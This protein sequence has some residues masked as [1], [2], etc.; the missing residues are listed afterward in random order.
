MSVQGKDDS[1]KEDEQEFSKRPQILFRKL[2]EHSTDI[3]TLIAADGRVSYVSPSI[4]EMLGY[5]PQE[6]VGLHALS[7]IHPDDLSKM[8]RLFTEIMQSSRYRLSAEYR[9]RCKDGAWRWFEGTATNLLH[10][11]DVQAI[12]GNF[13][14]ITERKALEEELKKSKAQL[15]AI[16][17]NV[18]DG[19]TAQDAAGKLIYANQAAALS[20]G[21]ASIEAV[22][23]APP[24][25][26]IERFE[27]TDEYGQPFSPS[28]FPGRRALMG[29][30]HPQVTIKHVHKQTK[31]VRWSIITST[32]ILS[33]EKRP[34][35]VINVIQDITRLKELEQRKD[36]FISMASH[37]LR[38][39]VTS[40]K[41]YTQLL[42]KK[43]EREHYNE[44]VVYLGRMD[45][46]INKL[47][48]LIK[49]LLDVSKAQ[50]GKLEYAQECVDIDA[51]IQETIETVQQ[52][53]TTHRFFVHG[54]S[55]V[56][57]NGDGERLGQVLINLLNNAIKYS[58][59]AN[60]VDIEVDTSPDVVRITVRDYGIGIPQ[61]HQDKLFERFYRVS[62]AK[63]NTF[64]GLG[65]GLYIAYEIVLR[66]GGKLWLES[67]EGQGSAF[68]ISLPLLKNAEN[69]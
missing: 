45:A 49:D 68:S 59:G 39:P 36:T 12:V 33:D 57:V 56:F 11:Q 31:E 1:R 65:I 22:M 44:A 7:L 47:T 10:D 66:H 20:M 5:T 69:K 64:P 54:N 9:L 24:L 63:D 50:A 46:Q 35:L 28:Q 53:S 58:P 23:A 4:T 43:F 25:E 18:A 42:I 27:I 30:E 32:V 51:L 60:R 3:I 40:V 13:R 6:V 26:Y 61:E 29:E 15:E 19:I 62:T 21:Y 34:F 41:A 2:V 38:T 14:D 48:N 37:E 16:L 52:T 67:E 55:R 17:R 8:Q